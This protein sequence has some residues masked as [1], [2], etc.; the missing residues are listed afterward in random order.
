MSHTKV[1]KINL[2]PG[3]SRLQVKAMRYRNHNKYISLGILI[4]W[5]SITL[6]AF[7][8]TAFMNYSL[9][10]SVASLDSAN[11]AFSQYKDVV[12]AT[13]KLRFSAKQVGDV[14]ANRFEYAQ[15]FENFS[16]LY[17]PNVFLIKTFELKEKK[18]FSVSGNILSFAGQEAL[19][20]LVKDINSGKIEGF[21]RAKL[22]TLV[23]QRKSGWD[24]TMEVEL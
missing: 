4:F 10:K 16:K 12:F 18:A 6:I 5:I 20:K 23:W 22:S 24:F 9:S 17:D 3:A 19:E 8:V 2:L 7:A 1:Q 15:A 13:G 21:S 14:L 11:A